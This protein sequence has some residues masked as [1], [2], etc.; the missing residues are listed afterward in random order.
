M[1][2]AGAVLVGAGIGFSIASDT[3]IDEQ[4]NPQPRVSSARPQLGLSACFTF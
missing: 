1:Y 4:K 2:A 3:D